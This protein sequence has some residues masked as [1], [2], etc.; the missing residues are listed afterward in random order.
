MRRTSRWVS[1]AFA[2]LLVGLLL[3]CVVAGFLYYGRGVAR[4]LSSG[5]YR[6]ADLR[7]RAGGEIRE[8]ANRADGEADADAVIRDA[9]HVR[10]LTCGGA[11]RQVH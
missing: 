5:P 6:D 8:V 2:S 9:V 3:G 7:V 1:I 4:H 10:S 11:G